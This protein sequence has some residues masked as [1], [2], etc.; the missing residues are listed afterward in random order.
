M[1]DPLETVIAFLSED[2]SLEAL[3]GDRIAA[4]HRYAE[5]WTVG[6]AALVVRVDGGNPEL[7]V[8]VQRVRIETQCY[9]ASQVEAMEIWRRLVE[10]SRE[11][12][13]WTVE[14]GSGTALLHFFLQSSAPSL[15]WNDEVGMDFA[16][17]FFEVMVGEGGLND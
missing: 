8:P 13:R 2:A 5:T 9:A 3:V 6:E 16:L 11:I 7:Y 17:C 10:I 4:K 1:I 14:T 12:E 15:L